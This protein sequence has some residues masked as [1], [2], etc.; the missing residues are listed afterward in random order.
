MTITIRPINFE[1]I[2]PIWKSFLWKDRVSAI[3]PTSSMKLDRTNDVSIHTKYTPYFCG[4][5]VD[6]VIA[7]VNSCHQTG[8]NEFRSRGIYVFPEYRMMGLSQHLFQFVED[9]AFENKCSV[10][11]SLPRV[12]ALDAYKKFGFKE[13]SEIINNGV[14]FGPNVYV[15]LEL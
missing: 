13:C 9:R 10:L 6:G 8:E 14:E 5:Y 15:R 2:L 3:T 11:W 1:Q 7:G 4:V 12:S